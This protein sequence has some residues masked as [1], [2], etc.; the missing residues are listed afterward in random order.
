MRSVF[1]PGL[2]QLYNGEYEKGL[3]TVLVGLPLFGL[4]LWGLV[5]LVAPYFPTNP[6]PMSSFDTA[7]AIVGIFGYGLLVA[8]SVWD[9]WQVSTR[10]SG[11][12]G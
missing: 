7:L 3:I 2:G 4:A 9:A 10:Q 6:Q 11:E 5:S 1:F 12:T 8:W